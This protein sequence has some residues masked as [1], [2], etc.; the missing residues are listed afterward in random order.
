MREFKS[1]VNVP[2]VQSV[3]ALAPNVGLYEPGRQGKHD[4][5]SKRPAKSTYSP[6]E[7]G[8]QPVPVAA[9]RLPAGQRVHR[10]APR[11]RSLPSVQSTHSPE[12]SSCVCS[13]HSEQT[14]KASSRREDGA[15]QRTHPLP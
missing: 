14:S 11:R 6:G 2:A 10:V 15:G 13:S 1:D 4:D 8:M 9:W 7:H 3:H 5:G 12:P